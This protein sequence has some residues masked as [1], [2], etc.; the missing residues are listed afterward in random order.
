MKTIHYSASSVMPNTTGVVGLQVLDLDEPELIVALV[1]II[2]WAL[3]DGVQPQP[4]FLW[5]NQCDAIH[6]PATG[7]VHTQYG[8]CWSS[9]TDAVD[10]LVKVGKLRRTLKD[11]A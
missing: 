3:A 10:H 2:G 11:A 8:E 4:L 7:H 9:L 1:P 6:D 5:N